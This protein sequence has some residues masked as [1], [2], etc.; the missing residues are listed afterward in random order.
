M[1]KIKSSVALYGSVE[2]NI[3]IP[4]SDVGLFKSLAS[5][6]GWTL[7]TAVKQYSNN[8]SNLDNISIDDLKSAV[9]EA[10]LIAEGKADGLPVDELLN[11]MNDKEIIE[12]F[13]TL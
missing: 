6:F 10:M 9:N 4:L 11:T 2:M 13:K 1:G 3:S 7:S 8:D 12:A 5:R